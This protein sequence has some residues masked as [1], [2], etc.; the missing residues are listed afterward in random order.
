MWSLRKEFSKYAVVGIS[1]FLFDIGSLI[2]LKEY[3][4]FSPVVSVV[5]NQAVILS[6]NFT[7]NKYWSF[8]NK[9]IPHKQ[10]VR[11]LTLAAWNYTFSVGVMYV[12]HHVMGY[13]YIL[14]RIGSIAVMV[15]WNFLLYKYW[16]Y[17]D[18]IWEDG[19]DA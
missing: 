1:S 2:L 18:P 14:V 12:F 8:H 15:S 10:L 3:V 11:Y 13:D 5:V 7:L 4:G 6:Y 19:K 16:V 17:T 9:A